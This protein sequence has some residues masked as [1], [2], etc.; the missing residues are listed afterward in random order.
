MTRE[1]AEEV[2]KKMAW[3]VHKCERFLML[4]SRASY[5]KPNEREAVLKDA[6]WIDGTI[7]T[8]IQYTQ[9]KREKLTKARRKI[10]EKY[11][12]TIF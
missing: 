1:K 5:L 3:E 8:Q 2:C 11:G 9:R 12:I 7:P 6:L 4:V 10:A